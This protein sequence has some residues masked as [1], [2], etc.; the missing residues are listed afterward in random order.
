MIYSRH[1]VIGAQM[2]ITRVNPTTRL[3]MWR[4]SLRQAASLNWPIFSLCEHSL[5]SLNGL[6]TFLLHSFST[7]AIITQR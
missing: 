1:Q 2:G 6:V 4:P 3:G 7:L 5:V